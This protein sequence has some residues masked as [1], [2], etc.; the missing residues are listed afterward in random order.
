MTPR[1]GGRRR[2]T[3]R[4][5]IATS[6]TTGVVGATRWRVG[7]RLRRRVIQRQGPNLGVAGLRA[8]LMD[9]PG[10]AQQ[11]M[12]AQNL[13]VGSLNAEPPDLGV[14][15]LNAEVWSL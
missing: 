3:R 14:A 11:S 9:P 7:P 1:Y 13:G 2:V 6:R 4:R 12:V 10:A 15:R 5:G 8:E